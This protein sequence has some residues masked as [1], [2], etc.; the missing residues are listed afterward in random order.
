MAELVVLPRS[1]ALRSLA[2]E[3]TRGRAT[4]QCPEYRAAEG[5]A[6]QGSN[7]QRNVSNLPRL[8]TELRSGLARRVE[9]LV[10]Y[11]WSPCRE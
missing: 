3:T 4:G 6:R 5:M 9:Y 11:R 8:G 2:L 1:G 7:M 10:A